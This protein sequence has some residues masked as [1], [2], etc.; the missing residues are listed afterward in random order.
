MTTNNKKI[1][2]IKRI[3]DLRFRMGQT[4]SQYDLIVNTLSEG[5]LNYYLELTKDE[6][7]YENI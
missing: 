5:Q 1:A 4:P 3:D 6:F 7:Y 2:I